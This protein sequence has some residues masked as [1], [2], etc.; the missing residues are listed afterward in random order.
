MKAL[1]LLAKIQW[2]AVSDHRDDTNHGPDIPDIQAVFREG[3]F[4]EFMAE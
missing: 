1:T 3:C 4:P 2:V